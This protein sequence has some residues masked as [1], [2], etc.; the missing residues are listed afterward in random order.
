MQ[1]WQTIRD[2]YTGY[3]SYLWYEITHP[4]W[5]NYFYWLLGLSAFFFGLELLR[6]WRKNQPKFRKDFWLDF[7]YMFF[8]Y[9]L[10]ALIIFHALSSVVGNA[11]ESFLKPIQILGEVR[12]FFSGLPIF[13][14]LLFGFIFMDFIQWNTHRLLHRVPWLW[15]FHKVHHSVKQMGFAAHLRYHWMENVVYKSIQFIPL[16]FIGY[17]LRDFFVIHILATA[18]GHFNHSNFMLSTKTKGFWGTLILG[19]LLLFGLGI[20]EMLSQMLSQSSNYFSVA[21]ILITLLA[22]S[23]LLAN[24][25]GRFYSWFFNSPEMHIWHHAKHLPADRPYG[26]NYGLTLALWDYLFGTAYIPH[27]GKDEELGFEGD[28]SFP[29]TFV[30]Q[31]VHGLAPKPVTPKKPLQ[32]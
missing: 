18:I 21:L 4:A 9:F 25:M 12:A 2:S 24:P 30:K 32:V 8:N 17:D 19:S 6:P 28:E 7:F 26:V 31:Q 15:E 23:Y 3:A 13:W 14:H 11:F 22:F 29:Q 5:H 16:L 20:H 27:S 1:I 10:F